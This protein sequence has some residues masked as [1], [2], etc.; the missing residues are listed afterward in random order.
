MHGFDRGNRLGQLAYNTLYNDEDDTR[1]NGDYL[2]AYALDSLSPS[3]EAPLGRF[4]NGG[5][6]VFKSSAVAA[7]HGT[8]G[9]STPGEQEDLQYIFDKSVPDSGYMVTRANDGSYVITGEGDKQL[10]KGT[11]PRCLEWLQKNR[12]T[13]AHMMYKWK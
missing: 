13:Y 5:A 11:E 1:Y 7:Y 4:Y 12:D 6:I 2:F 9:S 3:H 10:F 8:D